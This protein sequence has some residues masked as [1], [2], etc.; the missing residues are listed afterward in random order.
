MMLGNRAATE[1]EI[2]D[3]CR[4]NVRRHGEDG[5]LLWAGV[6][7]NSHQPRLTWRRSNWLVRRLVV[8]LTR[9]PLTR[10]RVVWATCGHPECV[11]EDHI[12]AGSRGD[13]IR[14]LMAQGKYPRGMARS[15]NVA[16]CRGKHAK[17][18]VKEHPVVLRMRAEGMTFQAIG[19][20][21]GVH[22]STVQSFVSRWARLDTG[23]GR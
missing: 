18:G 12:K 5:C 15:M 11:A 2:L 9:G 1:V 23:A 13:N 14:W 22:W 21:Y 17:L 16:M 4:T 3:W 6:F 19:H 20:Q 8:T 10:G 7:S